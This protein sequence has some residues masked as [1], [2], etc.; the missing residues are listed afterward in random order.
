MSAQELDAVLERHR[1]KAMRDRFATFAIVGLL[2]AHTH[3][4]YGIGH[5]GLV[6]MAYA[7]SDAMLTF[8]EGK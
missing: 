8:T 2:A 5:A 3:E 1:A 4:R 7:V 6:E